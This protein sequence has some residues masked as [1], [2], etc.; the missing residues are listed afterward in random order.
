MD[1]SI[2]KLLAQFESDLSE[3]IGKDLAYELVQYGRSPSVVK[4]KSLIAE[5]IETLSDVKKYAILGLIEEH[6]G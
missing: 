6:C 5:G 2:D 1:T 3:I 4:A